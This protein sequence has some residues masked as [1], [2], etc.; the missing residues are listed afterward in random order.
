MKEYSTLSQ[1]QKT[2]IIYDLYVNKK[3]SFAEIADIYSTY[4]NK[5][6]RDAKSFNIPIRDKS[7][8]QKSALKT[9]KH[10]HPTKG[11]ERSEIVKNKIGKSVMNSWE[12]LD[13]QELNKRKNTAK[14]NWEKM[15]SDKKK[16]IQKRATDAVREASKTGSKLE[17]Y[18]LNRLLEDG[19]IVDFHK[20]HS[21]VN[22]KLQIDLFLPNL[23]IAIEVDGP[24]HFSPVWGD[25]VLKR[26]ISYDR[27]KQGLIIGKGWHLIRVKQRKDFSQSRSR[28]LYEK[29]TKEI[30]GMRDKSSQQPMSIT[31]ED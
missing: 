22:T 7:Q 6:L 21:L 12:S 26:N 30:N 14:K 23:N 11:K 1:K 13:E 28:V 5:I 17:H 19:H 10:K 2:E 18:L 25:E 15:S 20:E 4:P 31:I 27:K 8:A 9:G 29:L 16:F 24:S 3:K